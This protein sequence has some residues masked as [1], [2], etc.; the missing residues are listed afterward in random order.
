MDLQLL[1]VA[2]TS[3]PAMSLLDIARGP[4][5]KAAIAIFFFGITWRLAGIF[6]LR[7]NWQLSLSRHSGIQPWKGAARSIFTLRRP[8]LS[9]ARRSRVESAAD[10][11]IA[12]G[13]RSWP[14]PPFVRRT[15]Y[16]ETIGYLYHLGLGI[17]VVLAAPHI[18]FMKS[19]FGVSWP[20]LPT[21]II[22]FIAVLTLAT[23]FAVLIRRI[24]SPPLR[25]L[26]NF[27]D[28]FSWAVVTLVFATGLMA[29]GH[30]GGPYQ[31]VLAWHILSFDLLLAWFPFGKLMH[32]F[33]LTPSRAVAGY[34]LKRRG[35][36]V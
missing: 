1:N 31:D 15:L 22:T 4:A 23:L 17:V 8:R 30:V 13:S 34:L 12:V 20:S 18:L 7:H 24:T 27:D 26:S 5:L 36:P 16:G 9:Q 6:L 28:Y 2:H 14:H 33:F 3:G 32:A 10:A 11:A 25:H 35:A 19:V 29:H 21:P